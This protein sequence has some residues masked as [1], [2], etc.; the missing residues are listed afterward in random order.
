MVTQQYLILSGEGTGPGG[1]QLVAT[2]DL[3]IKQR[4]TR[5]RCG[6]DRWA[7]AYDLSEAYETAYGETVCPDLESREMRS[8]GNAL[9]DD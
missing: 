3:G 9:A 8:I 7:R 4:L 5:E 1:W 2:T 6:G